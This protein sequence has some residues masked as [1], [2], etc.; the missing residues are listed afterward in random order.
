M[1]RVSSRAMRVEEPTVLVSVPVIAA[2]SD[3][4]AN[5]LAGST[6]LKYLGR[7]TGKRV[8]LPSPEDA[9]KYPYPD[10]DRALIEAQ[11]AEMIVGN[12]ATV[13]KGLVL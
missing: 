4:H 3:E 10:E 2:D 7:R 11:F 1:Y 8:L 6:K 13:A 12:P 9:A 5:W